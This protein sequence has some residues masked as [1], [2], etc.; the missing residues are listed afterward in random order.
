[1]DTEIRF[2]KFTALLLITLITA[3]FALSGCAEE[4]IPV[5]GSVD[6][7]N[8]PAVIAAKPAVEVAKVEKSEK[9]YDYRQIELA[10]G[11]KV[12]TVE[13]FSCPIVAVQVWYHVGSKN[14]NPAR[15]G[16]AHM[17]E[18]MMFKGTDLVGEQD[19]F[20]FVQLV[21]GSNNGVRA[22]FPVRI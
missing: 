19:H 3:V 14:E 10:N 4:I 16:F 1:M 21:G 7:V 8:A 15:Q 18:H 22:I 13:D 20:N 6:D 2:T 5:A 9:L 12:V 11:M 17:F